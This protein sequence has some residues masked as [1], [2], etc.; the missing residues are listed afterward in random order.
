VGQ[1]QVGWLA[2]RIKKEEKKLALVYVG[3]FPFGLLYGYS[4]F[5]YE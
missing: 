3:Y 4:K 5:W 1:R 2:A